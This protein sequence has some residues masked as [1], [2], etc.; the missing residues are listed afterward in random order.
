M[1]SRT[2]IT[3]IFIFLCCSFISILPA[4]A[5]RYWNTAAQFNGTGYIAVVPGLQLQ[6]LSGNFTV[7][8][9]VNPS[10]NGAGTLFGKD[11]IRLMIDDLTPTTC[12][13][14]LQTNNNTKFYSRLGVPM[15]INK[16]Y[17][18]AC[19]YDA[20]GTGSM[21]FYVN[22]LLDTSRTGLNLGPTPGTDSLFIGHSPSYGNHTGMLDDIRIWNRPLTQM[23]IQS[24]MRNPYVGSISSNTNFGTGL[25]LSAPF[26]FPYTGGGYLYFYDGYNGYYNRGAA[27]VIIGNNPSIT[28]ATNNSLQLNGTTAYARMTQNADINFTAPVTVEAWIYPVNSAGAAAQYIIK[29]GSDYFM[30]LDNTGKLRYG[31]HNVAGASTVIIPSNQWTHIAMT[32]EAGGTGTLYLNGKIE[33]SG[34]FGASPTPGIDTLM[35]G[36]YTSNS[37]FYN[38]YI[39]AI[40][41]SNFVKTAADITKDMFIIIE[42]NNKPAPPNSTVSMNFD[43]YNYSST[44]IGGYYPLMND[45]KYSSAGTVD[46]TPVSPLLGLN[47]PY[48]P[49]GY[50][51]KYSGKRI[52][53]AGTAG[54]M[55]EDSLFISNS[56]PIS[57]VKLF[58]ALNHTRQ[59]DLQIKLVAPNGDSLIVFDQNYGLTQN[60][61]NIITVFDDMADS[62]LLN[63]RYVSFD[64]RIKPLHPL[65]S[66]FAGHNHQGIWKL[67]ITDFYNGNTGMLYGWG[68]RINN[69]V[70][71]KQISNTVPEEYKLSQNYPN[72]FNPTT[73]IQYSIPKSGLVKLVVFDMLGREVETLVNENQ[74]PG[75]YEVLL[76]AGRNSSGV[77]FYRLTTNSFNETKWMLLIK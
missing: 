30:Y 74:T 59:A 24:N 32:C 18:L 61:D 31:F 10:Q 2:F 36:A 69:S 67:R 3:A 41:I 26:E 4:N 52:P 27:E 54:Y 64:P 39:D 48:F 11:G 51:M 6:N 42:W 15:Q 25:I 75:T 40:K 7:E 70:G 12:R 1:K 66:F 73:K 44:S 19:T 46:D 65:N 9:W 72:P 63:G 37:G 45:A 53:D 76:D 20:S 43:Y 17:H 38:G 58:I 14:R 77:Y 33:N 28:D 21:K 22:G 47:I 60:S 68:L 55:K 23:E 56:T 62:S 57:D 5:Q 13:G 16:W 34:N 49:A 71:I 35:I 8:C 29:K 50:I